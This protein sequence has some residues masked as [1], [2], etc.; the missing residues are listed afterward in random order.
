[1]EGSGGRFERFYFLFYVDNDCRNA[2]FTKK[3][4][5]R[6]IQ[7]QH[8]F[9]TYELQQWLVPEL[10]VVIFFFSSL[11]ILNLIIDR[12]KEIFITFTFD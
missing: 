7:P 9:Q 5:F 3:T 10:W 1:L 6:T 11:C 4:T 12:D 2:H 8:L